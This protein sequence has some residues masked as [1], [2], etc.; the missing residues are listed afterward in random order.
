LR[1]AD[2]GLGVEVWE[3]GGVLRCDALDYHGVIGFAIGDKGEE[4]FLGI[5]F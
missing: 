4:M 5:A 1:K 2:F 3:E